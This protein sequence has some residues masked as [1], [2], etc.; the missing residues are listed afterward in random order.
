MPTESIA[1]AFVAAD[2]TT[3]FVKTVKEDF[4]VWSNRHFIEHPRLIAG[5][6]NMAV[7]RRW[8]TQFYPNGDT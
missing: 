5:E 1:D 6:G 4:D 7:Y 8:T 2:L 3:M